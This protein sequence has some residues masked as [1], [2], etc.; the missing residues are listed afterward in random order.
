VHPLRIS[1]SSL[2]ISRAHDLLGPRLHHAWGRNG[3][4][5][6]LVNRIH[7]LGS[8]IISPFA[9]RGHVDKTRYDT[10]SILKFLTA[11]FG[12]EPPPGVNVGYLTAGLRE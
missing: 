6:V 3:T 7:W 2:A 5:N 11:R 1:R 8:T 12:L 4:T 10:T 9:R